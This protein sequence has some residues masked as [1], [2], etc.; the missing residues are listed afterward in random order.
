MHSQELLAQAQQGNPKVIAAILN[1]ALKPRGITAQ[2][3]RRETCLYVLLRAIAVPPKAEAI[4]LVFKLLHQ[5]DAKPIETISIHGQRT[6]DKSIAWKQEILLRTERPAPPT[7]A[8][9]VT[10]TADPSPTNPGAPAADSSPILPVPTKPV[11]EAVELEL[12]PEAV[13]L[14]LEVAPVS[15]LEV[16]ASVTQPLDAQPLDAQPVD[17]QPVD[18]QPVDAQPVD[19][20]PLDADAQPLD[21]QPVDAQPVDAQPVDAQPV[22]AQ[23][24]DADAQPLD[25]QPVDALNA[26]NSLA[27]NPWDEPTAALVEAQK[28]S[29]EPTPNVAAPSSYGENAIASTSLTRDLPSPKLEE[30]L[31]RP[32]AVVLLLFVTVLILW[33]AYLDLTESAWED[34]DI[35]LSSEALAQRL[36]VSRATI[37]R[38]KN[39]EDFSA[40]TQTLDPEGIAWM[41]VTP[42]FIPALM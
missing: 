37:Y 30:V 1:H 20:Q 35:A 40:W 25:A 41:Y 21:A 7:F 32:E 34:A 3:A 22:D 8:F 12:V 14:E 5:L 13:E 39:K 4:A 19:A 42:K 28:G 11:P 17:A 26:V 27:P 18:A 2:V 33:Q 6:G 38:R 31:R 9:D 36:G 10:Q 24:L 16:L 23:P 15:P 29:L